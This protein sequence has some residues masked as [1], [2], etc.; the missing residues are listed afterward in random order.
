MKQKT[1][2]KAVLSDGAMIVIS[3][4]G[5]LGRSRVPGYLAYIQ[6]LSSNTHWKQPKVEN[7][8]Q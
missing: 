1:C 8:I 4:V 6:H 7:K 3:A 2:N 5:R